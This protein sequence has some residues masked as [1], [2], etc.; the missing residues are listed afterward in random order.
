MRSKMQMQSTR[1]IK[2]LG[3]R[4]AALLVLAASVMG[5]V[6]ACQSSPSSRWKLLSKSPGAAL[7]QV[8]LPGGNQQAY[9]QTFDLAQVQIDQ[10]TGTIAR[11]NP[12]GGLYSGGEGNSDSPYFPMRSPDAVLQ[13]YRQQAGQNLLGIINTA[14]FEDYQDSSRLSFP[15]KIAGK[16]VTGGSSPYGPIAHP[17]EPQY[18]T[19]RL[20]ALTWDGSTAA[21]VDYE[22]VSGAP[23]SNPAIQNGI[24]SYEYRDHPSYRLAQDPPNRYHVLGT[25]DRDGRPGDEMLAI[26]T[27][28][29]ATLEETAN[30]L[31]KSSLN[32][33]SPLITVDG[34]TSTYLYRV[35]MG[36]LLQPQ[37]VGAQAARLPHYLGFRRK[38][39]G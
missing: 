5:V 4:L 3:F 25:F 7:Y 20:K 9:V 12:G 26:A 33:R 37:N 35:E 31:R 21:I 11:A 34:G 28:N 22:P 19:V 39:E 24:V 16:L 6:V 1:M 15:I 23:L 18:R 8:T 17:A 10:L 14:F 32:I 2:N 30:L 36:V 38:A 29:P 27:A 13:R